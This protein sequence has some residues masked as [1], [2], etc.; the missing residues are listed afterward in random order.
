MFD[1]DYILNLEKVQKIKYPNIEMMRDFLIKFP[2]NRVK[3]YRPLKWEYDK[4][5]N[6]LGASKWKDDYEVIE[7][8][9]Y[10]YT[11][12]MITELSSK[13][14]SNLTNDLVPKQYKEENYEN[15][16]RGHC[17]HTV[18]TLF[19]LLD[20]NTLYPMRS[21]EKLYPYRMANKE[22]HYHWW[23]EDIKTNTRI[24]ITSPQF[25]KLPY[26]TEYAYKSGEPTKWYSFKQTPISKTFKLIKRIQ[27]TAE[28]YRTYIHPSKD[29]PSLELFFK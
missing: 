17:Y 21:I 5:S 9:Q 19:Y 27:P 2:N 8:L 13:I 1:D 24:D 10:P 20:T 28:H 14:L 29:S 7:F 6:Y 15:P 3:L 12:E 11:Q 18:Q 16:L 26:T 4:T 23:L 22:V 25:D